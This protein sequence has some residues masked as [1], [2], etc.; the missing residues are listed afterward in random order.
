M[1]GEGGRF[2]D[3]DVEESE[4]CQKKADFEISGTDPG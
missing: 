3:I 1:S 4:L 2:H